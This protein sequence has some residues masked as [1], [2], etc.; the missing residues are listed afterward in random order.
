MN[1]IQTEEVRHSR[2]GASSMSRWSNCPGSVKQTVA[3]GDSAHKT[4]EAAAQGTAAH[5]V[6]SMALEQGKETWE[7]IGQSIAVEDFTFEV[8]PD[9]A[10]AVSLYVSFIREKMDQFPGARLLIEH[11]MA[12]IYDEDAFGTGDTII[13]VPGDRLIVVDYKH[14]EGVVVEP[15]SSQN[16]YYGYLGL[17]SIG[18][19]VQVVECY[20]VQPRIPHPKGPIRKY[21]TSPKELNAWWFEVSLPAMAATREDDPMLQIGE[22]CR[23]C[24]AKEAGTCPA[25][26]KEALEFDTSVDPVHMTAEEIGAI[27]DKKD[28][29]VKFFQAVER[30]ALTRARNGESIPGRKLVYGKA[31]RVWKEGADKALIET[32]GDDA[33]SE[34][35]LKTPPAIEKLDGGKTFVTK[36]AYK[37]QTD[38]TL[39]ATSDKREAVRP[40]MDMA[41]TDSE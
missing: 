19:D 15:D 8:D 26:K 24:A 36:F 4:N 22:W 6:G 10:D 37:P 34:P 3:L 35:S 9:M 5:L 29:V 11:G 16:K 28:P 1:A 20:I 38:L 2:L 41:D 32:F 31:N 13:H 18:D 25:L 30:L 7:F 33:Y 23:F 40:L 12:S 39:A 14:G 21:V 17:E 27:L